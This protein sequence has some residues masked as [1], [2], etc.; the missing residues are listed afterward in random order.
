MN[1]K[2]LVK[3]LKDARG[4]ATSLMEAAATIAVG[5]VLAG[6]AISGG[7]D[8]I[9]HSKIEA[10]KSD[11]A[12]LGQAFMNFFKDTNVYPMFKDGLKTG[13][14]DEFFSI[15]VSENG[16]YPSPDQ[17]DTWLIQTPLFYAPN[18][19]KFGHQMALQHDSI[20]GHLVNNI[21]TNGTTQSS[22]PVRGFLPADPSRG[23]NGPYIDR[24]P[25]TDPWGN[26]YLINVQELSTK[27]INQFHKIIGQPL[28]RRV[29]LVLSAG[30][31][32]LIETSSEQLFETFQVQGDDIAFRIR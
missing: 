10:A 19:G 14:D 32:R 1:I 21:I 9:D 26:K 24:L 23:W 13:P 31:N 7:L 4:V 2:K 17:G 25:K 28:P 27:H 29:V 15:L 20:E 8:A 6:V 11:A 3:A 12:V 18:V 30:P 5:T 22:Y 16:T